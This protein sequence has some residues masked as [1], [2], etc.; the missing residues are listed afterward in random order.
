MRE[1]RPLKGM[2]VALLAADGSH[3]DEIEQTQHALR[4][5]GAEV[6]IIA[7]EAGSLRTMRDGEPGDFVSVDATLAQ[8]DPADFDALVIPGGPLGCDRLRTIGRALEFVREFDSQAKLIAAI[9]H[10]PSVLLSAGL[11]PDRKLTSHPA[12]KEDIQQAGARWVDQPV[13]VDYN[14]VTARSPRDIA[15]FIKEAVDLFSAYW[16]Q[17]SVVQEQR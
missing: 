13:V 2:R 7:P 8:A 1:N 14:W 10:G 9:G 16:R 15:L 12:L 11:L 3:Q 6:R 17:Q 4:D 5:L